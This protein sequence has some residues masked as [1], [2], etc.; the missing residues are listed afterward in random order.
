MYLS[1]FGVEDSRISKNKEDH[2]ASVPTTAA[3]GGAAGG[4]IGHV[5][6]NP[7]KAMNYIKAT[8]KG[9]LIHVPVKRA[10]AVGAGLGALY[11]GYKSVKYNAAADRRAG[12]KARRAAARTSQPA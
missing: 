4:F 8:K 1:A 10:A 6:G 5:Y 9:S 12:A 11:G 7:K 2:R 3:V